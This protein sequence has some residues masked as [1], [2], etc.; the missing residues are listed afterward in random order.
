MK[1]WKQLM[2]QVPGGVKIAQV[3]R[4]QGVCRNSATK[5]LV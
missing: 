4:Y 2:S 5:G 3:E 1:E